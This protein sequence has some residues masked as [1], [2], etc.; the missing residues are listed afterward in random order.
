MALTPMPGL[1]RNLKADASK[2][3]S[4]RSI[5]GSTFNATEVISIEPVEWSVHNTKLVVRGHDEAGVEDERVC[6]YDRDNIKTLLNGVTIIGTTIE[7]M[8]VDLNSKGFDF[9]IEDLELV[10]GKVVAKVNSIGYYNGDETPADCTDKLWIYEGLTDLDKAFTQNFINDASIGKLVYNGTETI[11]PWNPNGSGQMSLQYLGE[12]MGD[13]LYRPRIVRAYLD[14][15][16]PS[17]Q[18]LPYIQNFTNDH[19]VVKLSYYYRRGDVFEQSINEQPVENRKIIDVLTSVFGTG[20]LNTTMTIT[21]RQA[22][23]VNDVAEWDAVNQGGWLTGIGWEESVDKMITEVAFTLCPNEVCQPT[24]INFPASF[25]ILQGFSGS[26]EPYKIKLRLLTPDAVSS[27]VTETI[28]VTPSTPGVEANGTQFSTI[29]VIKAWMESKG[30]TFDTGGGGIHNFE[31]FNSDI[32]GADGSLS[33]ANPNRV[34]RAILNV[35]PVVANLA[36]GNPARDNDLYLRAIDYDRVELGKF[37]L[38]ERDSGIAV[39]S[40]GVQLYM[41]R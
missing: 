8:I 5:L 4:L 6:F 2:N 33:A 13:S 21:T 1:R 15:G 37:I 39:K 28:S 7:E 12:F 3:K 29:R 25:A 34:K 27:D 9:T 38:D 20:Q 35:L 10:E 11:G 16:G 14:E 40:C 30:L 19:H 22:T 18:A 24:Y 23:S 17:N 32:A 36:P 41:G 26:S 31:I